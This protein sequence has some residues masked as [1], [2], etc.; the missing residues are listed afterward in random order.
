MSNLE[1]W[2]KVKRPPKDALKTIQG[3]RLRGMTD[4]NPQWRY[5]ILT[6]L[7]G[8]CGKWWGYE[9]KRLWLEPALDEIVA[10]AEIVLWY[11]DSNNDS[12]KNIPGI[13]GSKFVAKESG[14]LRANDEAFKMAVTDALS[15]ACKMLG[16]GAD[17]YSGRWDGS[18]YND[19]VEGLT[20]EQAEKIK[21]LI[22]ETGADEAKFLKYMGADSVEAIT[23]YSKAI[24]ALEAKKKATKPTA[25]QIKKL[26]ELA[27]LMKFENIDEQIPKMSRQ[28]IEY[29]ITKWENDLKGER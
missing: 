7:F 12:I 6:E 16:I 21:A 10:F 22:K 8:P 5:K 20:P 18:K 26:K 15:V 14:G 13:G 19:P 27:K 1:I 4:I 9:I 24:A 3:G 28:D 17:V 29:L 2:E 11:Y 23:D 25:A